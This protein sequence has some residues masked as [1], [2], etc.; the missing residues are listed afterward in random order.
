M[1]SQQRNDEKITSYKKAMNAVFF[2]TTGLVKT[3]KL[4]GQ[5]KVT[6]NWCTNECLPEILEVNECYWANVS[7]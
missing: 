6:A 1:I 7:P 3:V 2:R 5:K 4:E